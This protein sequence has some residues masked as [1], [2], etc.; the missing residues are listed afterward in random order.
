MN[1][2]LAR[3]YLAL[4]GVDPAPPSR[5]ALT[6][7]TTAHLARVPFENLSKLIGHG[8]GEPPGVPPIARYLDGIEH[9][10]LGGTCY[11]CAFGLHALLGHLGYEVRLCGAAMTRP[12]VHV[13]NVVTLDGE[14]WLVDV[15]YGAPLLAPLP[16]GSRRPQTVV[17]GAEQ[18]TLQPR[19]TTGRSR[20]EHRRDGEV[21]HGYTLDPAARRTAYFAPMIADSFRPGAGFL[22][23]LRVARHDGRR[24]ISVRDRTV[25]VV[26]GD[27][28]RQRILDADEEL[29]GVVEVLLKIPASVTAEALAALARN[30]ASGAP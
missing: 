27:A 15:G 30:R 26:D 23:R 17:R 20:L 28:V 8:R 21:V 6:A 10:A 2:E 3:R 1:A 5:S 19:D 9:L 12:D 13:V 18:W 24:T 4:L 16:L 11:A 14:D 7:I 29:C 22:T 25:T